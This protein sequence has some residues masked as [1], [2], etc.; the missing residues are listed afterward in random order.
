M[1]RPDRT[2]TRAWR[3]GVQ[4]ARVE[5]GRP[6]RANTA[7]ALGPDELAAAMELARTERIERDI[8]AYGIRKRDQS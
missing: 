7:A 2:I 1:S 3:Q 8:A 4:T 6:A 5:S